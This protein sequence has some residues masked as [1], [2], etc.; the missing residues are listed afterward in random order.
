MTK[1][2]EIPKKYLKEF[3][4]YCNSSFGRCGTMSDCVDCRKRWV[5]FKKLVEVEK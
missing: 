1:H 2:F 3:H 5:K 4:E